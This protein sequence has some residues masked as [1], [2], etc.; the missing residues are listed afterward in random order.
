MTLEQYVLDIK[1]EEEEKKIYEVMKEA[2]TAVSKYTI[3]KLWKALEE[4]FPEDETC[5]RFQTNIIQYL[6]NV[7]E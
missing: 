1:D 6:S 2:S 4:V 7:N 5:R 3:E